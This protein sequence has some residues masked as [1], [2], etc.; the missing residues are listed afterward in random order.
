M[1]DNKFRKNFH[2]DHCKHLETFNL[3]DTQNQYYTFIWQKIQPLLKCII[4]IYGAKRNLW[5]KILQKLK[6]VFV[7]KLYYP[8][9][10]SNVEEI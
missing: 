4:V 5:S 7:I 10:C 1:Y 9:L 8:E 6:V 3:S 2:I